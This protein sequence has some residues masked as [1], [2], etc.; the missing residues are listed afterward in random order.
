MEYKLIVLLFG[1]IF[2]YNSI[3]TEANGKD[4]CNDGKCDKIEPKE[5]KSQDGDSIQFRKKGV[6]RQDMKY[7]QAVENDADLGEWNG[8]DVCKK[9]TWVD[10]SFQ[11]FDEDYDYI[12]RIV[13]GCAEAWPNK[14][15][16]Q[17]TNRNHIS[18]TD[19]GIWPPQYRKCYTF[20]N[21]P[22]NSILL[23]IAFVTKK[24][25]GYAHPALI[26]LNFKCA[27]ANNTWMNADATHSKDWKPL[28]CDSN[29]GICSIN[30]QAV[31][32]GE[33]T[34]ITNVK[35]GCCPFPK[36]FWKTGLGRDA[37]A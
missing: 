13:L 20:P 11:A 15:A 34:Y 26:D 18:T 14:T 3:H 28:E 12:P 10:T 7:I 27:N 16:E 35:I 37:W 5:K 9:N 1:L 4:M 32:V 25:V 33:K 36:I 22:P 24:P 19:S 21:T 8:E 31:K 30:N 6:K 29:S 23:G 2:A 17:V